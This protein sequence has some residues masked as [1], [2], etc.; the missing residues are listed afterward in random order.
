[1][2]EHHPEAGPDHRETAPRRPSGNWWRWPLRIVGLLLFLVVLAVTTIV[3]ALR[4]D[5]GTAWVIEQIPGLAVDDG[6][7]SL[8]GH[9]QAERL[10]WQGYGVGVRAVK[11]DIDWSPSCLLHASLCL[12]RLAA[13]Q[14]SVTLEDSGE[15][16]STDAPSLPGIDLPIS[17]DIREVRLGTLVVNGS[18]V[19]DQL[20]FRGQASGAALNVE[21]LSYRRQQVQVNA[22]GRVETR[23][24]WPLDLR[25]EASLPPP[26]GEHWRLVLNLSG[27]VRDVRVN[28]ESKGYL[29]AA[30]EGG[31][32]PLQPGL[33]ANARLRA[34]RFRAHDSLPETLTLEDWRL[35][36]SGS[37]AK[38][39]ETRSQA[40]LADAAPGIEATVF[41]QVTLQG[42]SDLELTLSGPASG[43]SGQGTGSLT[44]TGQA[45]WS[46]GLVASGEA[47][48]ER[49]PWYGLVPDMAPPAVQLERARGDLSYRDG[50]F[51]GDLQADVD[52]PTGPAGLE[53]SVTGDRSRVQVTRLVMT[54]DGG[55][56]RGEG[57]VT[58]ASSVSWQ[59]SAVLEAF[60]P[61]YWLPVPEA[62][63]DGDVKTEGHT[64]AGGL[65]A[66]SARWDLGGTWQQ[67]TA[68][69]EGRLSSEDDNWLLEQFR[70]V[71]GDNRIE[72][73][74]QYG[75]S[76]EADLRA[77]LP[78]PEQLLPGLSGKLSGDLAV[79]GSPD[80]PEGELTL[81]GSGLRWQDSVLVERADLEARV[82]RNGRL[83][84]ELNARDVRAY[85]QELSKLSAGI[86]GSLDDHRLTLEAANPEAS[87][88]L[89]FVGGLDEQFQQWQGV[90]E[91]GRIDIPGPDQT[92][93]LTGPADL[94]VS[95]EGDT[96]LGA[97]CWRWQDSSVCAEDQ[98][99]WPEPRIEYLVRGLPASALEPL[100][101]AD[102]RWQADLE[103]DIAL[104]MSDQG[105]SGEMHLDAGDG[106]FEIRVKDDWQQLAHRMFTVDLAL[107]PEQADLQVRLQ[108][109]ELGDLGLDLAVDPV[110][111]DR[112]VEGQF[113]V[114]DLDLALLQ[115]IAG[116]ETIA[117]R[118]NGQVRL[119]G[120]LLR[121]DT[122]GELALSDGRI[123][124]PSLPM[125]VEEAFAT[126]RFRGQS[127]DVSGGWQSNDR[128][129]GRVDGSVRWAGEPEFSLTL[130]GQRLPV[131]YEPYARVEAAPELDIR[132]RGGELSITGEVQV[133]RGEI[134]IPDLPESAVSVSEDEVIVGIEKQEP[135]IRR[136]AMDVT[137]VVG[138]DRVTFEA[139]GVTGDL[140]GTLRI[141][142]NMETRGA[143][144]LTNGQYEAFGQELSLRRARVQFVGPLTRPY[145]DIEAVR[146]V[147]T[148][149]AG[150]RLSGPV[151]EPETEV[152]SEPPMSQNEA[153]SYIV[154]GRPPQGQSDQG[155]LSRAAIS[156]GL[157]QAS[158]FTRGI[159]EELG[160]RNLV[161]E[162]EGSGDE[163]SVVA[164]GD[165][166]EDLSLRYAVGIFEPV[167]TVALRYQLGRYFYLEAASGLAASLDIFYNRDF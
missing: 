99:L 38:G 63:L 66:F 52:G 130:T 20:E 151:D 166:T 61:G 79:R 51:E 32:Q 92:W 160:I 22:E 105:A 140:A 17:L 21:R 36:L 37:L 74:G 15:S 75:R 98:R 81:T 135:A 109:P 77:E 112:Q 103:A 110:T 13:E 48:L 6:R 84:G 96:T 97:H 167:T 121:P 35:A 43:D 88:S 24:D 26:S 72:G 153:L 69:A 87:L 148:V 107:S 106:R 41:G 136:L 19:W 157:T 33:P 150:I 101:P 82:S 60:N 161:V 145:L 56:L 90:V 42:V 7:G 152:F 127:A 76:L 59:A 141:G 117:G 12:E 28:G 53:A 78:Q 116:L 137:V 27:S 155:Q 124:D 100:L 93:Q 91:Q 39:F 40:T 31:V 29:E 163:A 102:L 70:L 144:R 143:L 131:T 8:L 47:R 159:G 44:L 132:F 147:D 139:F 45:D 57:T 55:S 4:T 156:L 85:G 80:Q 71:V 108:G 165:I 62:S 142:D 120:P 18:K 111:E 118:V 162:A 11:P 1:M 104:S 125:P 46:D 14:V 123:F 89:R 3:L 122:R 134:E 146:T 68:R 126:L 67:Q 86:E 58:L 64:V 50:V 119:S 94:S 10:Q 30:L 164:S 5:A 133:P 65:P 149:V 95:R 154:L 138:G 54:S 83:K 114:S 158:R 129:N 115:P 34:P 23:G 16:D 25:L 2:S 73:R 9:W 113:R 49:F 128:S